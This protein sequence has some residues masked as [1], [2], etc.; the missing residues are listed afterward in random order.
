MHRQNDMSLPIKFRSK[1]SASLIPGRDDVLWKELQQSL[2]DQ[3]PNPTREGCPGPEMLERIA[4]RSMSL[5]EA[6]QWLDHLAHC[7][8]CFRDFESIRSRRPSYRRMAWIAAAAA[9]IVVCSALA[10]RTWYVKS[11]AMHASLPQPAP[12]TLPQSTPLAPQVAT[13]DLQHPSRIRG[14]ASE[15]ELQRLARSQLSVSIYLPIDSGP[16]NYEF[17]FQLNPTDS[18]PLAQMRGVAHKEA[19]HTVLHTTVDLSHLEPGT[20]VIAFRRGRSPWMFS[21]VEIS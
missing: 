2:G 4:R 10:F 8:P 5:P 3:F 6:E 13:L 16:G 7:S 14:T 1:H 19:G 9:V 20:Y 17:R 11:P 18:Q 21:R 15:P 12:T